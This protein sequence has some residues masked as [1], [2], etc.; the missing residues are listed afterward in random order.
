MSES[1]Q[2]SFRQEVEVA[3]KGIFHPNIVQLIGAGKDIIMKDGKPRG[4]ESFYII[5]EL[6]SNGEMFEYIQLAE[7]LPEPISITLFRQIVNAVGAVHAKSIAHRDIKLENIFLDKSVNT[8]LA[9]FGMQKQ[10][11]SDKLLQTQ[12]GT[13]QYMAPELMGEQIDYDGTKVD[14]FALGQVLYT[15]MFANH[16]FWKST[17]KHY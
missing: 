7:G 5:S 4:K 15:M 3:S 1:T 9:D 13:D 16:A 10:F 2:A 14:I 11:S 8:K 17:D 12:C 6:C